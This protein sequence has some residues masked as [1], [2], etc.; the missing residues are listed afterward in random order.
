MS[1][2]SC[3]Q[4]GKGRFVSCKSLPTLRVDDQKIGILSQLPDQDLEKFLSHSSATGGQTHATLRV[5]AESQIAK[6]RTAQSYHKGE[7]IDSR[8]ET[9]KRNAMDLEELRGHLQD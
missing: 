8:I 6:K 9:T 5:H 4:H 2:P 1:W 7:P 3:C